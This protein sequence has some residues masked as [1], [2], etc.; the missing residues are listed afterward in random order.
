MARRATWGIFDQGLSSLTNVGLS[1][2]VAHVTTKREFGAFSLAFA[3]YVLAL[4]AYRAIT[5]SPFLIRHAAEGS[6]RQ[7]RHR[8]AV[9]GAALLTAILC[10]LVL[11]LCG[12]AVGG[13]LRGPFIAMAAV[14]PLLLVQDAWRFIYFGQQRQDRACFVDI[15]WV[16]PQVALYG[17]VFTFGLASPV[18]LIVSWGGSA[19]VAAVA[20]CVAA[21]AWPRI[22]SGAQFLRSHRDLIPNLFFEYV[23]FTGTVQSLPYVIGGV[24]GLG[25]AGAIRGAQV[26]LGFF[27]VVRMGVVPI[28][29]V[30]AI[31][32]Y[33]Q[34]PRSLPRLI[35]LYGGVM[36]VITLVYGLC[37]LAIPDSLGRALVGDTWSH[38]RPL[39]LALTAMYVGQCVTEAVVTGLRARVAVAESLRLR[40]VVSTVLVIAA[41]VGLFLAGV[42]GAAWGM[43]AGGLLGAV[44][45]RI[46]WSMRSVRRDPKL[47]PADPDGVT[48]DDAR[49]DVTPAAHSFKET[50]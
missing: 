22:I 35:S 7:R 5:T 24:A 13:A 45:S 25:A 36:A 2:A 50:T 48:V 34:R 23:A 40:I 12:L 27:N 49:Q 31:R 39:V 17:V 28:V 30:A 8:P 38:A 46:M 42:Q 41:L 29:T 9:L 3:G 10:S 37:V 32:T 15:A 18:W 19:G 26:V 47:R 4:G 16:V 6:D 14:L 20:A 11:A 44:Q 21:G 43:A 33:A 1:I